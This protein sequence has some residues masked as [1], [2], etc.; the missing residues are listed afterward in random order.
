MQP[1]ALTTSP[2]LEVGGEVLH[3]F[4]H[5]ADCFADGDYAI[6]VEIFHGPERMICQEEK[7]NH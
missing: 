6:S 5:I 2:Q 1:Q 3:I 4:W 7:V